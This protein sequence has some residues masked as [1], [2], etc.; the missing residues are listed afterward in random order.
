MTLWVKYNNTDKS[1]KNILET[2]WQCQCADY[3]YDSFNN[4]RKCDIKSGSSLTLS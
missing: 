2:F 1:V 3:S 4:I